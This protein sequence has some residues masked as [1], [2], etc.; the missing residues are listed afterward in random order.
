[1]S[2]YFK[3]Q[4]PDFFT[5]VGLRKY[6]HA[7]WFSERKFGERALLDSGDVIKPF[8][9]A[10]MNFPVDAG[11]SVEIVAEAGNNVTMLITGLG[12]NL[13]VQD[14]VVI[15]TT[16]S[17][18][19]AIPGSWSRITGARNIGTAAIATSN[20]IIRQ[21]GGGITFME[22]LPKDQRSLAAV[23]TIPLGH[24][25]QF[26]S[27][28]VSMEKTTGATDGLVPEIYSQ[29]PGGAPEV[30]E[31]ANGV[32]RDGNTAFNIVNSVPQPNPGG[33]NII[34]RSRATTNGIMDCGYNFNVIYSDN[35]KV[36]I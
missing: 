8:G 23:T 27:G 19:L 30:L 5:A 25:L 28:V 7:G 13:T 17:T 12:P 11:E 33:I 14:P 15:I 2:A 24:T 36:I 22:I 21:A 31:F 34:I 26:I 18:P 29:L 10:D 20:V 3:P 9:T 35:S 6:E 1:M 16:G 32:Q 4:I